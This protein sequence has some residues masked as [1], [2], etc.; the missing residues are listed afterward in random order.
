MQVAA[1]E[2]RG[3]VSARLRLRFGSLGVGALGHYD[4]VA[5]GNG[6][7]GIGTLGRWGI[8]IGLGLG[9]G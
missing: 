6:A 4:I 8:G 7:L 1:L 5:L 9:L 2:V 3:H